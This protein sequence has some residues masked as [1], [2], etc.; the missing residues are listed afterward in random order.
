MILICIKIQDKLDK[1][2][3]R[4]IMKIKNLMESE[5]QMRSMIKNIYIL[6]KI[7]TGNAILTM[8]NKKHSIINLINNEKKLF[9]KTKKDLVVKWQ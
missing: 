2:Q 6:K 9:V 7:L 3:Q 5:L 8:N 4:S 1:K